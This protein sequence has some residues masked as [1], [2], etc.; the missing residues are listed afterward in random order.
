MI[1]EPPR[2][3]KADKAK[4]RCKRFISS[5]SAETLLYL[6]SFLIFL[7]HYEKLILCA[8]DMTEGGLMHMGPRLILGMKSHFQT[9][10]L[11]FCAQEVKQLSVNL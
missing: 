5:K 2:R 11:A 3:A 8:D 7:L 1:S 10:S 4:Q 6:F 9:F